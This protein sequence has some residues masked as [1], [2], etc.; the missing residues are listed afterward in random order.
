MRVWWFP[1]G[2]FHAGGLGFRVWASGFRVRYGVP[3]R[4]LGFPVF[5]GVGLWCWDS[6]V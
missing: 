3:A 6:G 5:V 4:G 1:K 2:G